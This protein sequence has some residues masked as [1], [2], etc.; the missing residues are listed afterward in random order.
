MSDS[1]H[2]VYKGESMKSGLNNR[3][4]EGQKLDRFYPLNCM[5]CGK[6][7]EGIKSGYL[8]SWDCESCGFHMEAEFI[9]DKDNK[10]EE[11]Q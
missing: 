10:T 5:S 2:Q 4:S 9:P 8:I 6:A 1:K 7:L 11:I 3:G